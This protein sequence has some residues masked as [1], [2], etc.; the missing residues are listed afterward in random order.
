[1]SKKSDHVY[2]G[3]VI[4]FTAAANEFCKYA[5]RASELKGDELLRIL[6]RILPYLY[7][8]ASLLPSLEPFFEEGNTKSVTE[9]DWIIIRDHLKSKF[10]AAND[11]IEVFDEKMKESEGPVVV[12]LAENMADIYQDLK[13]YLILYR[14]GTN[15]VMND[16]IWECRLNFENYWGQKLTNSLRAIHKFIYSGEETDQADII[17]DNP[18]EKDTSEWFISRRQNEFR[19]DGQQ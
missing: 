12:S 5:E 8:K 18:E 17:D 14:T 2:S 1:M 4:E 11:F 3:I 6:Q 15:E 10:G 16:A 19:E 7:L 9:T 13:N